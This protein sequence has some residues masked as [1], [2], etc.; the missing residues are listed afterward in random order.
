MRCL[1]LLV[2]LGGIFSSFNSYAQDACVKARK[3]LDK[4]NSIHVAP[5]NVNDTLSTEIFSEF[6]RI[7]DGDGMLF[8]SKDTGTLVRYRTR[9]DDANDAAC[10]FLSASKALYKKKLEWYKSFTDSVLAKPLDLTK[11]ELGPPVLHGSY[12]ITRS[13]NEL[14][15]KIIHELKVK[16][17]LGIY[18]H[19][20]ADSTILTNASAFTKTEAIVRQRVKKNDGLEIEKFLKDDKALGK[21]VDDSYLK[22]IPAVFDPHSTFFTKEEMD[23]FSQSL[24]PSALS[25]GIKLSE[26]AMGEVS[27]SQVV[28]GSPAWNSNQVNKGDVLIGL[29]W[30]PSNE[31]V[32][33]SDLDIESISDVIEKQGET[34]AEITIRK[35]TGETR[36]VKLAKA[37]IENEENIVSGFVLK[38][39]SSKR[40][41][42]Y[43]SLPGFFTDVDKEMSGCAAAVTKEIIKL[44]GESIEGLILD[45]RFNGGGSLYEAVELAG[46]FID[47]GPVGV[48]EMRGQAPKL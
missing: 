48:V 34:Q 15:A 2:A 38:G 20:A 26:S 1:W 6:F 35:S 24:N 22:A 8:I 5:R 17:L 31:Y 27:V 12:Q 14:K 30:K 13:T 42:G 43:I 39:K 23:E 33:L 25:F 16:V 46:L 11:N 45:L 4:I 19:A 36:N 3:L 44:K 18:R 32:D 37:K 28:P 41:I 9:L 29:R 21:E 7:L 10:I 40:S 47:V